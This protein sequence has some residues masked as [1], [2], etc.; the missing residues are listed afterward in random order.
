VASRSVV[1]V[2]VVVV[3]AVHDLIGH[4]RVDTAS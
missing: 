4:V 1:V 3:V 2:V